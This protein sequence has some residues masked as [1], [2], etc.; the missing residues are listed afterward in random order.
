MDSNLQNRMFMF[1]VHMAFLIF[2]FFFFG[3][4][5]ENH[6][7]RG[8]THGVF[9]FSFFFFVCGENHSARG[10]RNDWSTRKGINVKFNFASFSFTRFIL[11]HY[12]FFYLHLNSTNLVDLL[13]LE[14]QHSLRC[15]ITGFQ[16][17]YK[18]C[19]SHWSVSS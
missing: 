11:R 19:L 2:K 7:E 13:A 18:T 9:H 15:N 6:S 17:F 1:T 8:S 10:S 12:I 14:I 16:Q 3:V 5:G 4:R